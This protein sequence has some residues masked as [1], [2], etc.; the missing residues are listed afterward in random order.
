MF[1][2]TIKDVLLE[3]D[4]EII[5]PMG[6]D[7]SGKTTLANAIG[8]AD[9]VR[10]TLRMRPDRIVVGEM[11]DGAPALETPK[12]WNTSHP[13][14]LSALHAN[15]STE[16]LLRIGDLIAEVAC[17]APSRMIGRV[18]TFVVRPADVASKR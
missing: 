13:G 1:T 5:Q 12:S 6:L 4:S 7:G 8:V 14:G 17:R 10:D 2:S 11:C 16:A 15:S 18:P 9:L 3:G